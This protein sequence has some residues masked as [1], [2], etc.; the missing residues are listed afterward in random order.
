MK[1]LVTIAMLTLALASAAGGAMLGVRLGQA[2]SA[3]AERQLM[4]VSAEGALPASAGAVRSAG[5]FT[6]FDGARGLKGEALRSGTVRSVAGGTMVIASPE[7][8]LNL[9]Y[10]RAERFFTIARTT[11]PLRADDL[12]QVFVRDGV[13]TGVLRVPASIEQGANR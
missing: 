2:A 9:R 7:S 12:V 1:R 11:T 6:G 13:A 3:P 4:L 8:T 10:T 5:G